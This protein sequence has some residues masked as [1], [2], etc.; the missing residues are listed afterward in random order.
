MD[1]AS[2]K[3]YRADDATSSNNNNKV[4][5]TTQRVEELWAELSKAWPA[6]KN[7]PD[8]A[9]KIEKLWKILKASGNSHI[10]VSKEIQNLI[11][12]NTVDSDFTQSAAINPGY[13]I[14]N[15]IKTKAVDTA[16]Q[17][18]DEIDHL[19]AE[20]L[21]DDYKQE[22]T[23]SPSQ[24]YNEE[25]KTEA[26]SD[27]DGTEELDKLVASILGDDWLKEESST[28]NS[29]SSDNKQAA[30][31]TSNVKTSE[32]S[33][34]IF[35]TDHNIDSL[36]SSIIGNDSN[37]EVIKLT[38]DEVRTENQKL[39]DD[40]ED[41]DR[42]LNDI[43]NKD[44]IDENLTTNNNSPSDNI[45]DLNINKPTNENPD[46]NIDNDNDSTSIISNLSNITN[47]KQN[48]TAESKT[49]E[50]IDDL[51]NDI[52]NKDTDTIDTITDKE[53]NQITESNEEENIDDLINDIINKDTDTVDTTSSLSNI[54]DKEQNQTTESNEEE[55]ID[56][57]INDI[58]NK[59]T[60]AVDTTSSL[61]N[62]TDDE[63]TDDLIKDILEEKTETNIIEENKLNEEEI[64]ITSINENT[65]LQT[66]DSRKSN[67]VTPAPMLN[68]AETSTTY[69]QPEKESNNTLIIIILIILILACIGI[70][71]LF[72]SNNENIAENMITQE[73]YTAT[74]STTE[75]DNTVI[76][77]T[78]T[79]EKT[80]KT[81]PE[82]TP[83]TYQYETEAEPDSSVSSY[84][85]PAETNENDITI[86]LNTSE[87]A[88]AENDS[89]IFNENITAIEIEPLIAD[90]IDTIEKIVETTSPTETLGA[91]ELV[92]KESK[93]EKTEKIKVEK[94]VK[95]IAR[96]KVIIHVIVK[97][98]TLWAIAKRYVNNP[99]R[100]PELAR[101]SKIKNPDRIYPGNK[102]NIIV[103]IK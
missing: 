62:I 5:F 7:N 52:I 89:T 84:Y 79:P 37:E 80:Y 76:E 8:T 99:Y 31:T 65:S 47:E 72:F 64:I 49:E 67:K 101:L 82:Y 71:K 56:D 22:I 12:N 74:T 55:N 4:S 61:S 20:I 77:E 9:E 10:E 34:L 73:T 16:T 23:H 30:K 26:T 78:Y 66:S 29:I 36:V 54:T 88:I 60:D 63:N 14:S 58:I 41:I 96:R 42:L 95:I 68:T 87:T 24:T 28:T 102:V 6:I 57:L 17:A 90:N 39:I 97:G 86:T 83:K 98:D 44:D 100:Y 59:D 27:N 40:K 21:G 18:D 11:S 81:K 2:V 13:T 91:N 93:I 19:L 53:Q 38:T 46:K 69:K 45:Y 1:I 25:N 3:P 48:Q 85:T 33:N 103:Y 32:R 35:K 43:L 75:E 94:P 51:I 50:N 70:W 92:L 15:D